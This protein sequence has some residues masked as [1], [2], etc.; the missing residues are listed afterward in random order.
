MWQYFLE[1]AIF[2]LILQIIVVV[3]NRESRVSSRK[4]CEK[5]A[6]RLRLKYKEMVEEGKVSKWWEERKLQKL[7]ARLVREKEANPDNPNENSYL[8][9]SRD[10]KRELEVLSWD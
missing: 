2:F 1:F 8:E 5:Y 7:E 10:L 6:E 9:L 3:I 4:L